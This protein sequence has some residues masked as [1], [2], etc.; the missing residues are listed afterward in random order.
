MATPQASFSCHAS[1]KATPPG[2]AR[3]S[4]TPVLKLVTLLHMEPPCDAASAAWSMQSE[5][6]STSAR[7]SPR[8]AK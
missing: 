2:V 8:L 4:S 1:A 7:C 5:E 6:M 3:M